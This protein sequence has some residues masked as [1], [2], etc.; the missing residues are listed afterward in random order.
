[1]SKSNRLTR[2][3]QIMWLFI[4]A[5]C[6]VEASIIYTSE[7]EEKNSA[8]LFGGVALFAIFRFIV[9]R[10]QQLRKEEKID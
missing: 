8:L 9:L 4:A 6:A 7:P 10:R 5:V 3:V 2:V 1:M